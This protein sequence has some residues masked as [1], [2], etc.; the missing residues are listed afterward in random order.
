MESFPELTFPGL[1][2][3]LG[4]DSWAWIVYGKLAVSKAAD[5]NVMVTFHGK[6]VAILSEAEVYFGR[7]LPGESFQWVDQITQDN[8]L[9]EV[10]FYEGKMHVY[11]DGMWGSPGLPL[12]GKVVTVDVRDESDRGDVAS[13]AGGGRGEG[14]APG[15][16]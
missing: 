10:F 1:R 3:Y 16:P 2:A 9:G 6:T 5:H 14:T 4:D 15:D 8:H 13:D 11:P 7:N 12:E